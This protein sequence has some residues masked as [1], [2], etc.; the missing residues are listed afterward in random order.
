MKGIAL[1]WLKCLEEFPDWA[2][3][4]AVIDYLKDDT[5][6]RKPTPGQIR[7]LA[8]KAVSKYRVLLVRC[9]QILAAPI[10]EPHIPPTEEEKAEISRIVAETK[11]N[12]FAREI[13]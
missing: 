8:Q 10:E 11:R 12:I 3:E 9:N 2:V 5:K 6:G 4:K 13:S 7:E 1:Q